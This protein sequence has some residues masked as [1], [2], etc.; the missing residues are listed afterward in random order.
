MLVDRQGRSL[1]N[2]TVGLIT[3]EIFSCDMFC[4]FRGLLSYD[5]PVAK[6][7]T[8]FAENG[9]DDITVEQLL[10]H[11]VFLLCT[12]YHR[13]PVGYQAQTKAE[14]LRSTGDILR[15]QQTHQ[16]GLLNRYIWWFW[17]RRG[18]TQTGVSTHQ[19]SSS[20]STA[21]HSEYP[22]L[23]AGLAVLDQE[24]SAFDIMDSEKI[25]KIIAAQK[26]NWKPGT[27]IAACVKCI[28]AV[29]T[30]FP[31]VAACWALDCVAGTEHGYHGITL[32]LYIDQIVRRVD[33][34]RRSL[35]KFLEEEIAKPKGPE[36]N[37]RILS[38]QFL[39]K[40]ALFLFILICFLLKGVEIFL[41]LPKEEF[42]RC[43]RVKG[44]NPASV[45]TLTATRYWPVVWSYLT[46]S[47]SLT[48]RSI[49]NPPEYAEV[50]EHTSLFLKHFFVLSYLVLSHAGTVHCKRQKKRSVWNH[51]DI[52]CC[53][54]W[55]DITDSIK[56][57]DGMENHPEFK[58]IPNPSSHM[59]GTVK[60]FAKLFGN[61]AINTEKPDVSIVQCSL[62]SDGR[63]PKLINDMYF[64][65]VKGLTVYFLFGRESFCLT[66]P[67]PDCWSQWS[68]ART[69]FS[70][71][72]SPTDEA[73][74]YEH[75]HW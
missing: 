74:I 75:L 53:L 44:F 52:L 46:S 67:E 50:K 31:S 12:E 60:S 13:R 73:D 25:G 16:G 34:Q 65:T 40:T 33:P 7:W 66:K 1:A 32:G 35:Q 6:Y 58:Q 9:K 63:N 30:I 24:F 59:F 57:Q 5:Q 64:R 22:F 61:V 62:V 39:L 54:D 8:E 47:Q 2:S 11:Q 26:P 15:I 43:S 71:W 55:S 19:R 51:S 10:S 38:I 45:E 56:F 18:G 49:V 72:I 27:S 29:L 21:A 3:L 48:T 4:F 69:V 20:A 42:Y 70:S 14:S 28:A 17:K 41:G 23:Q 36:T 68:P 37:R